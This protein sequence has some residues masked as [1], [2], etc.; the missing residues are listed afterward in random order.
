MDPFHVVQ[1]AMDAL[2][3]VRREVWREAYDEV[4]RLKKEHPRKAGRPKD[5][6]AEASILRA[7]KT[8]A[9]AIWQKTEQENCIVLGADTIVVKDDEILGKP[10]DDQD[11]TRMIQMLQGNVHQV[12]TGVCFYYREEGT[13]I[14]KCHLFYGCTDV[15]VAPMS[16]Q[17]I[18]TYLQQGEHRDKAGAYGIQ[19]PCGIYIEKIDGDYNN[20]VGLPIARVYQE[21][22][23]LGL[24]EVGI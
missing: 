12:Y 5:D 3:E 8:K 1:W 16:R 13:D 24:Y 6:D 14:E 9:E 22:K 11:A 21:L 17:E 15:Q 10:K 23:E 20:V 2:D 4:Q 18:E 19:G 7:A